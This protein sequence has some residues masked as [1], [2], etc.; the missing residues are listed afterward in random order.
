[1]TYTIIT[2]TLTGQYFSDNFTSFPYGLIDKSVTGAGATTLALFNLED[3]I[4]CVPTVELIE[5]KLNSELPYPTIGVYANGAK[6]YQVDEYIKTSATKVY[7]AKSL[8]YIKSLGDNRKELRKG[9]PLKI[10]CTYN[11]LPNIVRWLG[12]ERCASTRLLIDEWH[13]LICSSG[14]RSEAN[15]GVVTHFQYFDRPSFI[16]ATPL[17][18]DHLPAQLM[19]LPRI[20]YE[21]ERTV[22]VRPVLVDSDDPIKAAA[23]MI[24]GFLL[25][26]LIVDSHAVGELFFF[27]NSV[28]DITTIIKTVNESNAVYLDGDNVKVVCSDNGFNRMRLANVDSSIGI[29]KA[30]H[31][32]A[33]INFYTS[34]AFQGV[35][36][37]SDSGLS[38]IVSTSKTHTQLPVEEACFQIAG[39]I[40]TKTNPFNHKYYHVYKN[41]DR[42]SKFTLEESVSYMK[43]QLAERFAASEA[44]IELLNSA[45][46]TVR[47]NELRAFQ[48]IGYY[49]MLVDDV[50]IADVFKYNQELYQID[51]VWKIYTSGAKLTEAYANHYEHV[52]IAEE[53]SLYSN[54]YCTDKSK[55]KRYFKDYCL[56]YVAVVLSGSTSELRQWDHDFPLLKQLARSVDYKAE[57]LEALLA[58]LKYSRTK[59]ERYLLD[60]DSLSR[61]SE[62][63]LKRHFLLNTSY[64]AKE[65]KSKLERVYKHLKLNK[66]ATATQLK[67]LADV[68]DSKDSKGYYRYTIKSFKGALV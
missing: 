22:T 30:D 48:Y 41:N 31:I 25:D 20:V 14:Y 37:Y 52:D 40:R 7:R 65:V 49:L 67:D 53:S 29:S 45:T 55:T 50:V 9:H 33:P 12:P 56:A 17:D 1:M 13:E 8:N 10:L 11:Q 35:D 19:E 15:W 24:A 27:V 23:N 64:T 3:Y 47:N 63:V 16:T 18:N 21:W 44:R 57:E 43:K 60:L 5:N 6:Q 58:K 39:R 34:K 42:S 38:I 59:I 68:V 46:E 36:I 51:R 32:N 62:E 54:T 61:I 28:E 2:E 4:I 66:K 26:G